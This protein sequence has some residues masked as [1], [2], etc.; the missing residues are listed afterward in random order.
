MAQWFLEIRMC[1]FCTGSLSDSIMRD[2]DSYEVRTKTGRFPWL[3]WTLHGPEK[4]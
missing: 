4:E 3:S 2:L 1:T